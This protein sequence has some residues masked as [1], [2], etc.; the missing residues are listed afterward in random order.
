MAQLSW[1][2]HVRLSAGAG[3][4]RAAGERERERQDGRWSAV[5]DGE[6]ERQECPGPECSRRRAAALL[7]SSSCKRGREGEDERGMSEGWAGWQRQRRARRR[8][9]MRGDVRA[10]I[11]Q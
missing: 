3:C 9:L 2:R 1:S 10:A 5:G 7:R 8:M 6:R 11:W 4:V